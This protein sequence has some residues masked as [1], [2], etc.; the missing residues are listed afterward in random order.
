[1]GRGARVFA[2]V[3]GEPEA[4]PE[5]ATQLALNV[6]QD[7]DAAAAVARITRDAGR[8]DVLVNNAGLIAPIGP[9]ASLPSAALAPA[10]AVNVM[11]LHRMVVACLPLLVAS[12]GSIVNAGTGAATTPMEGWT[13]YC[14][15]K[16]GAHMLTRM[17]ALELGPQGI[18]SYFVGIPPTDT[19]MQAEI[20][21]AGLNPIS[22]IPQDKLVPTAVPASV[23]AYMCSAEA[24]RI[25]E[26]L[27]DVRQDRFTAMMD[28]APE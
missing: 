12:R 5:G 13:A 9:L 28:L 17:L 24:R 20:R 11:G 7:A 15:S 18:A 6:T 22:R 4:L 27:L 25:D 2:G 26:V 8:L 23:L 21:A 10:F 19:A 14:T 1:M 16:A 3:Y